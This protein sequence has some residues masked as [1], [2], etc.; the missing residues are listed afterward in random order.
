MRNAKNVQVTTSLLWKAVKSGHYE[1]IYEN[2]IIQGLT[3]ED[4]H[5]LILEIIFH[6]NQEALT[7]ILRKRRLTTSFSDVKTKHLEIDILTAAASRDF[8]SSGHK[9]IGSVVMLDI[10]IEH[11]IVTSEDVFRHC[12]QFGRYQC[13]DQMTLYGLF[14]FDEIQDKDEIVKLAIKSESIEV[15]KFLQDQKILQDKSKFRDFVSSTCQIRE[16]LEFFDTNSAQENQTVLDLL[17][18]S[19]FYNSKLENQVTE[20]PLTSDHISLKDNIDNEVLPIPCR[21]QNINSRHWSLNQAVDMKCE[22]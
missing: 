6:C 19:P 9:T 5:S 1:I 12:C 2:D 7:N 8:C 4:Y 16:I 11:N 20:Y 3:N 21:L 18:N 22:W 10:L 17:G 14:D 15:L 13:L